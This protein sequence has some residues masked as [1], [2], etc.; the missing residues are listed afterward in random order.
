[1]GINAL[2][3]MLIPPPKYTVDRLVPC[4]IT[5]A[6]RV[7]ELFIIERGSPRLADLDK[8]D[9][10]TQLLA[11]TDDAYGFPPFRYLAPAISIGSQDY[12]EL[13]AA[14]RNILAGFLANVRVRT[15]AS[16]TFG[17]A[18]EIPHLI[19]ASAGPADASGNGASDS[20]SWAEQ[21]SRLMEA[22]DSRSSW[23]SGNGASANGASANG[24]SANGASANGASGNGH[25]APRTSSEAP[26]SLAAR[27]MA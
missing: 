14:E 26:P 16:D 21:S 13:R 7:R 9:A 6:T 11:N 8:H 18:D 15:L 19:A 25:G 20:F 17:W 5:D 23:A 27:W 10:L 1:M 2:T 22:G 24:A 12:H 4:Q 3:Q